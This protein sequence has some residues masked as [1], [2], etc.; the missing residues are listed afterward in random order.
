MDTIYRGKTCKYGSCILDVLSC[1]YELL[2]LETKSNNGVI[3]N[4]K[5]VYSVQDLP[6]IN[7]DNVGGFKNHV[8]NWRS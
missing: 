3:K 4:L 8:K 6:K 5:T 7:S 1:F 2:P